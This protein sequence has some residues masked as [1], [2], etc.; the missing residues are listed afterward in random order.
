MLYSKREYMEETIAAI[1]EKYGTVLNYLETEI[2]ITKEKQDKL[3]EL[4]LEK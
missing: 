1:K 3:R 4:Y 2:G